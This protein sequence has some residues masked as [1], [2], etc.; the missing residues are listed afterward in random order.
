M[1]PMSTSYTSGQLEA[2]IA[3]IEA[4]LQSAPHDA[5]GPYPFLDIAVSN[6]SIED[7]SILE[8]G[9]YKGGTIN[10]L[11]SRLPTRIIYGF[12]SFEGL[13]EDW[14]GGNPKGEYTL[15]GNLPAVRPNVRL[16]KGLFQD[17]LPDFA[18]AHPEPVAL[19]HVDCDIYSSTKC[20]FDHLHGSIV[21]G[22]VIAFDEIWNYPAFA[23]HEIKAFAEFLLDRNLTYECLQ[24]LH[25]RIFN[26]GLFIIRR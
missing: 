20:V 21:D 24:T 10:H 11:A 7:G 18:R 23:S 13:P 3:E 16:V 19:L 6:I 12:D 8:F 4:A 17:T 5:A 26:K 22:T 1:V 25:R 9:V 15:D 14:C 2:K